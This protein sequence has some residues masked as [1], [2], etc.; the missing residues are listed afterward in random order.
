MRTYSHISRKAP[1]TQ[2]GAPAI[3]STIAWSRARLDDV[4]IA[5]IALERAAR[6]IVASPSKGVLKDVN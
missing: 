4:S 1:A 2:P 5:S 6:V 3:Q